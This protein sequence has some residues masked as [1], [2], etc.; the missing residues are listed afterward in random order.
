MLVKAEA[1]WAP[2]I[3]RELPVSKFK[4]FGDVDVKVEPAV[5]VRYRDKRW[6]AKAMFPIQALVPDF[7]YSAHHDL[8][9]RLLR[10]DE[11]ASVSL[12]ERRDVPVAH[13]A[14]PCHVTHCDQ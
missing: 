12:M 8:I 2:G 11:S 9:R 14:R 3:I 4:G 6:N 13:Q 1:S 5:T 10:A 7:L